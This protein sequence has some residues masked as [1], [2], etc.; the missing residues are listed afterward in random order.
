[1]RQVL[2]D[3]ARQRNRKK[4]GG[5][6]KRVPLDSTL[7]FR[8][9]HSGQVDVELLDGALERLTQIDARAA[10]VVQLRFFGGLGCPEIAGLLGISLSS[11]ERDWRYAR[12]WLH[13]QLGQS[14]SC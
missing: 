9:E 12:A 14:E 2:V 1:M 4:R 7:L 3:H 6:R 10:E 5:G 11:V 8:D 13:G